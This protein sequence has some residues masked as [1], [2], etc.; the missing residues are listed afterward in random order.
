[1]K[2]II[3]TAKDAR[4][5]QE[6]GRLTIT[7]T[8]KGADAY[9]PGAYFRPFGPGEWIRTEPGDDLTDQTPSGTIHRPPVQIGDAVYIREPWKRSNE[10]EALIFSA[11]FTEEDAK[12]LGGWASPTS[13]PAD[14]AR[15][16]ARVEA[17]DTLYTETAAEWLITLQLVDKTAAEAIDAHQEPAVTAGVCKHCGQMIELG[18]GYATQEDADAAAEELCDCPTASIARR[19]RA[20]VEAAKGKVRQLFGEGAEE[21][22]FRPLAGEGAVDL[23]ERAVELIALGPISSATFNVRGQCKAKLTVSTKGKIKVSRS[24]VN[25]C[26]LEAGE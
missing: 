22:G 23:L 8:I 16:H 10:P 14:E 6:L 20:Q 19:K 2:N 11:D 24:E 21:L 7:K 26:D 15:R 12:A 13:M 5:L 9:T 4:E 17:I 18:G 1:M 25:S 3:L